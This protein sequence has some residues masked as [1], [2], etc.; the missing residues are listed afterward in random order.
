MMTYPR[1]LRGLTS[2]LATTYLSVAHALQEV[3]DTKCDCY[4]TNGSNSNYFTT[5]K[6]F[7]FRSLSQYAGVPP[8]IQDPYASSNALATSDFFTSV[9]WTEY[10]GI[11]KWNNTANIKS[12]D[13]PTLMVHSPNNIYIETNQDENPA[14]ETF[15]T[16]RTSRL[17]EYQSS[18]EFESVS[19]AYH[20]VSVR[21]FARTTGSPGAITAMFTY[22]DSGDP[23]QLAHVQESDLE[24][25]TRD[26]PDTIQYTNQ[27]SYSSKGDDVPEATRNVTVPGGLDWTK[28]AV[29]R[30]DWSPTSTTW[31]IDGDDVASISFQTPRDP[32]MIIFNAWSDGGYWAGNMSVGKE[33]T[34]QI[35]W[36]E[37][38][39]NSTGTDKTT[40]NNKRSEG[41]CG[42]VCSIDDTGTTG[43][44]VLL[45][46]GA[47]TSLAY[48]S[49]LGS[50]WIW[51]PLGALVFILT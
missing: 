34:L 43:T 23:T 25:R 51:I 12:G 32:S 35:Q 4:L 28:W 46:S 1:S 37:I 45:Q 48:L 47:T 14:S 3:S 40:D 44:P 16:L 29:H 19:E 2:I 10:W 31:F 49:G 30:M 7:D 38:V 41:S 26:P 11:Q 9:D 6:F 36:I 20:F 42:N 18:S 50:I 5:H 15:M 8:A 33:A 21:M 22:K 24:I 17:P 13:A 39:Y 27:P